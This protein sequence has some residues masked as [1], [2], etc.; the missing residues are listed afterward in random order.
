MIKYLAVAISI[1]AGTISVFNSLALHK[2]KTREI[3][4]VE[5]LDLSASVLGD[6]EARCSKLE[7]DNAAIKACV[8]YPETTYILK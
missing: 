2:V 5:A 8:F 1:I 7:R 3:Y 4:F 6:I